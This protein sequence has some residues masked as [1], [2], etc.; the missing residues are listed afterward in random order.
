MVESSSQV[1]ARASK[2]K[3]LLITIP[4]KMDENGTV[5]YNVVL[6][7]EFDESNA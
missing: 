3:S 4:S 7:K 6:T 1:R 5:F 2:A